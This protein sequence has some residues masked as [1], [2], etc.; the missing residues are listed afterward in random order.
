MSTRP[1]HTNTT[2]GSEASPSRRRLRIGGA[3]IGAVIAIYSVT[4]IA[5]LCLGLVTEQRTVQRDTELR[6]RVGKIWGNGHVQASPTV[7]LLAE[8]DPPR[9]P[10][11]PKR[12][13]SSRAYTPAARGERATP[14]RGKAPARTTAAQPANPPSA[15]RSSAA[16]SA[17][18]AKAAKRAA[19]P[20]VATPRSIALAFAAAAANKPAPAP[21]P[22]ACRDAQSLA[23]GSTR[24]KAQLDL[25]HRR[26]GLLWYATYRVRFEAAY[27]FQNPTPCA[28]RG[29]LDIVLP[30]R[31]A[32]YD[33]FRVVID[34]KEHPFNIVN[35]KGYAIARVALRID[36]NATRRV[37]LAYASRGLGRWSYAF[38]SSAA[39]A[40]D[41]TLD[42]RTNFGNIDFPDGTLAPTKKQRA[43]GGGWNLTWRFGNLLSDSSIAVV[44]PQKLNP[45]PLSAQISR[46][47]PISLLFFFGILL[48][49][50]VMRDVPLHPIHYGMLAAA[51]FSFHLL[52][53]Y[54][55]DQ[56]PL[57]AA[58]SIATAT[59]VTLVVSYLRLAVGSRFALSWAAGAQLLYLVLFSLAFFL[60]GYTGLTITIFSV[61]TLFVVMQLTARID[62]SRVFGSS[63][64]AGPR[65]LPGQPVGAPPVGAPPPPSP[66][67]PLAP[68]PAPAGAYPG[69]AATFHEVE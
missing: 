8:V 45:G 25:E 57:W 62:W 69:G 20:L 34:G 18:S 48:L 68:Q 1:E 21:L 23:P 50:S 22:E 2:P 35:D 30:S 5:W 12:S 15:E 64:A 47:A 4:A 38:G 3:Y 37:K 13:P 28:R 24:A 65:P 67:S 54:L 59:S 52:L 16:K 26:K 11:L 31:G 46:F 66:S 51:F 44:M 33:N 63:G 53:A 17:A 6:Q 14:W 19:K 39:R 56:L 10:E 27:S 60:Q 7:L 49:V 41:F 40:R 29:Q 58:F 36:A 61:L 43:E 32:A 55:V 9:R 42:V